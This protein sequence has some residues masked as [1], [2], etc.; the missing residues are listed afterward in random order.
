MMQGARGRKRFRGTNS[1]WV[2]GTLLVSALG[3]GNSGSSA[4]AGGGSGGGAASCV[5]GMQVAC[6][7]TNGADGAQS[8]KSDGS[9]FGACICTSQATAGASAGGTSGAGA[10][11]AGTSGAS[12][13][14]ARS[15]SGGESVGEAGAGGENQ[16][17]AGGDG[18]VTPGTATD[19]PEQPILVD[20]VPANAPELFAAAKDTSTNPLCV[21]E[22]QLSADTVPGAMFPSNWLRPR[23]RVAAADFD[24][25]EIR[26]HSAAESN[27]LVVY[28]KQK[29]WY[30]PKGIWRGS[31]VNAGLSVAASGG[32]VSVTIR[33]LNSSAP[34]TAARVSGSF[35][36]TP[37]VASGSILFPTAVPVPSTPDGS[38]VLGF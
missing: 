14:G 26:L 34:Q 8:C 13:G 22:P 5:P 24:L 29:T 4:Q 23:F 12:L 1:S 35:D 2:A 15:G 28:T 25:Y 31:G 37:A 16:A 27:D 6:A 19:F 9:G 38:K 3:C 10:S 32:A 20:G 17:G 11:G 33:A 7:C 36:I 30:L 18:A 21:L